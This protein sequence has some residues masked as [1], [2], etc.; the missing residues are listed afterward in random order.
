MKRADAGNPS[1]E[2]ALLCPNY[3]LVIYGRGLA[4]ALTGKLQHGV[5]TLVSESPVWRAAVTGQSAGAS[6]LQQG[7]PLTRNC[8]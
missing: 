7:F 5:T 2:A 8:T 1:H 4:L 6:V 3:S